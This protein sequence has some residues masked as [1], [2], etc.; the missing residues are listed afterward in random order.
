MNNNT[1]GM[2]ELLEMNT[3]STQY[4]VREVMSWMLLLNH[5]CGADIFKIRK[6]ARRWC[7]CECVL[8]ISLR[9]IKVSGGAM[10]KSHSVGGRPR[11]RPC[12]NAQAH[13]ISEQT[14]WL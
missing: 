9:E 8:E 6:N 3:E 12:A 2:S 5:S 7:N 14:Q 4:L 13:E 1:V 10:T 11:G